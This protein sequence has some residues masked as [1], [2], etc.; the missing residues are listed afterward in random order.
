MLLSKLNKL[1]QMQDD[2]SCGHIVNNNDN[3]NGDDSSNVNVDINDD[4]SV[5]DNNAS[6]DTCK[7]I[8]IVSYNARM[9]V[10]PSPLPPSL[11]PSLLMVLLLNRH[12]RLALV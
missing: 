2:N 1:M 9:H 5:D 4:I 3:D 12:Q 10:P 7:Q 6:E 8:I 11:P